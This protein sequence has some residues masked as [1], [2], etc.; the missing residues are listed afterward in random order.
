MNFLKYS[1]GSQK[2]AQEGGRSGSHEIAPEDASNRLKRKRTEEKAQEAP[3]QKRSYHDIR[4]SAFND[5]YTVLK[6]ADYLLE[7]SMLHLAKAYGDL[8]KN[9]NQSFAQIANVK[10]HLDANELLPPREYLMNQ[11]IVAYG[12]A[13]RENPNNLYVER[14]GRLTQKDVTT[15]NVGKFCEKALVCIIGSFNEILKQSIRKNPTTNTY[16]SRH[17]KH[18]KKVKKNE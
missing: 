16:V 3:P 10:D 15:L 7:S 1:N 11:V 12:L 4:K 14:L 8:I 6:E 9:F 13:Q 18:E 5:A 2:N 17:F